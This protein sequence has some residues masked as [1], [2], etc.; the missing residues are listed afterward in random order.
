MR[1]GCTWLKAGLSVKDHER[2]MLYDLTLKAQHVLRLHP[3]F[4]GVSRESQRWMPGD[5]RAIALLNAI[6]QLPQPFVCVTESNLQQN[7]L[8]TIA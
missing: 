2:Q 8:S 1:E 7:T 5:F 4:R 3:E 6:L